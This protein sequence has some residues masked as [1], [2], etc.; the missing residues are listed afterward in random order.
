MECLLC[1]QTFRGF[2]RYAK[3]GVCPGCESLARHRVLWLYLTRN[4]EVLRSGMRLLHFAA[5]PCLIR[6]FRR[7][8]GLSYTTADLSAPDVDVKT[9]ITNLDFLD[10]SFEVVICSHVL[11]HI[12]DDERAM[13]EMYRVLTPG[14]VALIQVPYADGQP[15]DEDP[16]VTDARER[17]ARWGQWDHVRRYGTDIVERMNRAGFRVNVERPVEGMTADEVFRYGLWNDVLFVCKKPV[18]SVARCP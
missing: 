3:H 18:E 17:E 12:P 1:G 11:E 14:G 4:P 13:S 6:H 8:P 2:V 5:E 15:T 16:A 7:S 10:S 9:D